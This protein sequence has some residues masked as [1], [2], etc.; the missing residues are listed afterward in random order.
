MNKI[1][2]FTGN[3]TFSMRKA[4]V[5][6]L[7]EFPST[8]FLVMHHQ[9]RK[10]LK[11]VARSQW[12]HLSK[13]GWRWVPHKVS[14]VAGPVCKRLRYVPPK[15]S[16]FPGT[17]FDADNI[18]RNDRIEYFETKWIHGKSSIG[19]LTEFTP[20]LGISLAGPILRP[21]LFEIPRLGTINLHKGKVPDYRGMPPAF[22]ELWNDELEVGVTIHRVEKGL[23]TGEILLERTLPRQKFSTVQ[24][25]QIGLDE[26]G[27]EMVCE[28][29][30]LLTTEQAK[31]KPQ[32]AGGNTYTTPTLKQTATLARR[33]AP[34][35]VDSVVRTSVKTAVFTGYN[36]V[37]RP[38]A[39]QLDRT[40]SVAILLY[41]RISDEIRDSVTVG[42]EQFN[43]QMA[44]IAEH[45]Q[46]VSTEDLYADR[47]PTSTNGKPL[48]AVTFDD[49]YLDN[50]M[51]AVPILLR[52]K[53]PATF[54]VTTGMIGQPIGF[55]H[56]LERLGRALPNMNWHQL[57]K[58]RSYGFTIGS[59]TVT[60]INCAKVEPDKLAWEL[61]VSRDRLKQ[62]LGLEEQIFAYPFGLETDITEDGIEMVKQAGYIGCMS[63]Y[64]GRNDGGIDPYN[65]LRFGVDYNFSLDALVAK[66]EG[67]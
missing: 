51:N 60:H 61:T 27:V 8:E 46:L 19:R 44:H 10:K 41:H 6:L 67:W 57:R 14:Q 4:L 56:D 5:V 36:H 25:M 11:R 47:L 65:V 3:L 35:R 39:R 15:R 23:D 55:Q 59:H 43:Q 64:G 17:Q 29:V 45:Y 52:N 30:Q 66:V 9:P 62:E 32:P 16:D 38:I 7:D 58:M 54:F 21:Q 1:A 13:N 50:Y 42:I 22:W 12:R 24:G 33:L 48:V 40:T 18:F 49:G 53:V 37:Y 20:D 2:I 31:W 63:A 34:Q 28:A 26:L